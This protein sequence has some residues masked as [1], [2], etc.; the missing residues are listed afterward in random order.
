MASPFFLVKKKE[1][2]LRPMQDYHKLNNATIK[3]HY[4]LPLVSKLIDKL[5][6]ARAFLI[7]D[8]RWR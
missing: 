5:G 7:M 2:A 6:S 1:G 4:P 8:V 3:N